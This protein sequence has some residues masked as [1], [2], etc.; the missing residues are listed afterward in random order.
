MLNNSPIRLNSTTFSIGG[1]PVYSEHVNRLIRGELLE[2]NYI[3]FF[4]DELRAESLGCYGHPVAETPHLDKLA[5]EGVRFDQCH[6][7][8]TVCSPSRCSLMTGWYPHVS[9]HRTLWHLLRP[10]EPSLF[11]YL[12]QEGYAIKWYGKN[13][14]YSNDY[15]KEILGEEA[16]LAQEEIFRSFTGDFRKRN[17]F[18]PEDPRFQSFLMEP[19]EGQAAE[20]T[21]TA[22]ALGKAV[23]F[24]L[25]DEAREKP[26]MLYLPT[27]LPH[28][29][30]VVP[31]PFHSKYLGRKLPPLRAAELA[32]KPSYHRFIREYRRLNELGEGDGT[33]EQIQAVYLG[34]VDYVDWAFGQLMEGL[35]ASGLADRTTVIVASDH[36]DY[37]GD[38]GLVEKWPNGMEDVLTRVPLIIRSPGNKAG[39]VVEE[40]VELFDIMATVL[41]LSGIEA[42]H[43]HFARSLVP[44]LAGA[45]GDPD[46]TVFAEG[47]YDPREPHCFEGDPVRDAWFAN[48]P[49]SIYYP[50]A[51]QQQEQPGSVSRSVMLRTARHKLVVRTGEQSELYDLERD[52]LELDNLYDNPG[53]RDRRLELEARLLRWYVH[54]SDVVPRDPDPG[55]FIPKGQP[56]PGQQNWKL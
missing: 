33:L 7:Q 36:G 53:Y 25:S 30:Y 21:E 48:N 6:V 31:E 26:F 29:P 47:G 51:R 12:K 3:F 50:K 4:P 39:H 18:A 55:H 37:A 46:R 20:S 1:F 15:L 19:E 11:R 24:L 23:S 22:Q 44:Q 16:E 9:G 13:H 42:R 56:G 28:A 52:P 14:L 32:G 35:E 40:P 45:P 5:R 41:E 34:M 54:T 8:N 49:L 38:Y 10:H 43:D 2:L 27:L 17:P